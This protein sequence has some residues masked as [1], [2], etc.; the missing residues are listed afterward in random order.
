MGG[1]RRDPGEGTRNRK[2]SL[3]IRG[4]AVIVAAAFAAMLPIVTAC[5]SGYQEGVLNLYPPADGADSVK[6]QADRCS[7]E[8]GGQYRI[9]TTPLPKAADDQRLQL[10]RRLAGN[11]HGLDLMGMDVVWTAEFA[12]AGWLV[13]VP[14]DQ[15]GQVTAATLGGPLETA[16]WRTPTDDHQRLYAMP[17]WTNT[18]LLWYRKDAVHDLG[19]RGAATTWQGMIAEAVKSGARGGPTQIMVQGRQYE[20][21]M[22]WFN[23]L[24]ASAGGQVVDPQDPGKVTLNDT[25]AHRAATVKALQVMKAVATAPGHDPSLSNSDESASRLGMESGSALYEVNWPFVFSGIREN[26][27]AGSVPFLPDMTRHNDFL[28]NLADPPTPDQLKELV[29]IN[30]EIRQKF[31]FAPY[32]GVGD[33][34]R[35]RSTLGGLNIA[36]ASTSQQRDLAFKAA[37]CLTSEQAQKFYSINAGTP[38]VNRALYDD[39]EFRATYPMGDLIKR[40]LEADNAALRPK[41][42]DYQAISTLLQAK[43][44][45]V[46]AWD[47]AVLVDQ[48]A[49]A[50]NKAINGEGLIP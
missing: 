10:A 17:I 45:P 21:L 3:G 7:Q 42:P 46:G 18:Q 11:D 4:K 38:P 35:P 12:D 34:L 41:S 25:P 5:G 27:A 16:L 14:Q 28:T 39:P 20:G 44:S 24:L 49:D 48:L 9:V 36:V 19:Q 22:V 37:L 15:V 29:P 13:P 40:Q 43:L 8:S 31:D 47:P 6:I 1:V 2:A 32:P 23:S 50:V 26:A 30:D 33:G